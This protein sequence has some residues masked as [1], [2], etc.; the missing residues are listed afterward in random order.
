MSVDFTEQTLKDSERLLR[1]GLLRR[2][3]LISIVQRG[4]LLSESGSRL[5]GQL[6]GIGRVGRALRARNR[7]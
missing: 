1:V 2:V 4:L 6:T 3:L 5:L 7:L